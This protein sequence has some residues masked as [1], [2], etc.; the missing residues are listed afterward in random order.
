MRAVVD[1]ENHRMPTSVMPKGVEHRQDLAVLTY[2]LVGMP[3]S[4]MPKGVEHWSAT[5]R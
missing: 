3:T 5:A 4:V 2:E 1:P